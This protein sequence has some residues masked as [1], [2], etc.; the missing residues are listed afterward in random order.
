MLQLPQ[1]L[2]MSTTL[3][4]PTIRTM[5]PKW[6]L[7]GQRPHLHSPADIRIKSLSGR[8][9][10]ERRGRNLVAQLFCLAIHSSIICSSTGSGTLP[11]SSTVLW[12]PLMLNL[13]PSAAL[14]L[15]RRSRMRIMP[16]L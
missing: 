15:A 11:V 10:I 16:I 14:A 4:V 13:S 12:K 2:T 1:L 6:K 3:T 5:K 7:I 8:Q 9:R